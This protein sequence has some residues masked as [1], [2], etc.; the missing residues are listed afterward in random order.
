MNNNVDD[1][2]QAHKD[3]LPRMN[4]END[5]TNQLLG[6]LAAA[7]HTHSTPGRSSTSSGTRWSK[8]EHKKL[9]RY[10]NWHDGKGLI[11]QSWNRR[12]CLVAQ[13]PLT[14]KA[15]MQSL[16]SNKWQQAIIEEHQSII[17]AG[18]CEVFDKKDLPNE[19]KPINS[20]WVFTVKL[21]S[22]G[23]VERYKARL[24][25]KG[26]SQIAG[27]DYEETF[28]PV[29]RYDSLRLI[30]A[31]AVNLGLFLEQLDIKTAFLNEDLDEEIW[32]IPPP[33]IGLEGK[34]LLLK[35]AL[36]GLK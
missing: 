18:V 34:T 1:W 15:V 13:E 30:M 32:M 20:K 26:Y 12:K 22:D 28:A 27:I 33:G 19:R 9:D 8:R 10:G 7:E 23:S 2:W 6:E 35:K 3:T 25:V 36:Y 11:T 14:Y 4:A 31:L 24:V 17:D 29:T 5:A 16:D 21:N